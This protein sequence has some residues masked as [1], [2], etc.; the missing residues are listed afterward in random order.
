[1]GRTRED[2]VDPPLSQG[3][4]VRAARSVLPS[5]LRQ[6]YAEK[7]LRVPS[8]LM[9]ARNRRDAPVLETALWFAA[10]TPESEDAL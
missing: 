1:M 5:Q 10:P 8:G 2:Q 4:D 3:L 7:I 6:S 9:I